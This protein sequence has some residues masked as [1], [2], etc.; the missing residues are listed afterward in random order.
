M[1]ARIRGDWPLSMP[2]RA[3]M[4]G[5]P[6]T[7]DGNSGGSSGLDRQ[8]DGFDRGKIELLRGAVD[9]EADDRAFDVEV[10]IQAI[11]DLAG[12]CAWPTG[13][14]DVEAVGLGVIVQLNGSGLSES[15]DRRRRYGSFPRRPRS[16]PA[17][18]EIFRPGCRKSVANGEFGHPI[19]SRAATAPIS[20][21]RTIRA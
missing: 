7:D 17:I 12:F 18:Y 8:R 19:V 15:F 5:E 21:L 16:R 4:E 11:R 2:N 20:R 9:I 6:S 3:W 1:R 10:R 14:F 13:E